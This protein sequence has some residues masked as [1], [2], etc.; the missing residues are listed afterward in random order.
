MLIKENDLNFNYD[1]KTV[2]SA[3]SNIEIKLN[4]KEQRNNFIVCIIHDF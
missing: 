1:F 2:Q 4:E 3:L